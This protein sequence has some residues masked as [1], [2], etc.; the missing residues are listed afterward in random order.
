MNIETFRDYCL[1]KQA[2][3]EG[4]PFDDKALV[5]KVA[6]K[7]FAI[8]NTEGDFSI[9]LKC[10]PEKA[11]ALREAYAPVKPGFHLSKKHWNTI[12]IDGFIPDSLL[13]AWITHSYDLVI[14]KM[15]KKLRAE[16]GL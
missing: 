2:V 15:P 9:S 6:G 3:T 8:T 13:E 10:D 1:A 14:D 5:F 7:M 16:F 11:I 12:D 4:F